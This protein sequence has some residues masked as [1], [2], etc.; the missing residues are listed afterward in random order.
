MV[1]ITTTGATRVT[2]ER[3]VTTTVKL[4]PLSGSGYPGYPPGMVP[5]MRKSR[6]TP[7]WGCFFT[8]VV[9]SCC[10][11]P[12]LLS[13]RYQTADMNNMSCALQGGFDLVWS[14]CSVEHV[15][16]IALGQGSRMLNTRGVS[17]F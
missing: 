10:R 3:Q 2:R 17:C 15:G 16:S 4:P 6:I 12:R 7:H 14:T 1:I 11:R 8:V 9:R 5:G 13:F